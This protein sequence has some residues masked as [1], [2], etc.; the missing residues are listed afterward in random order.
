MYNLPP[1]L[2]MHLSVKVCIA[3]FLVLCP[4][5]PLSGTYC[6]AD[7]KGPVLESSPEVNYNSSTRGARRTLKESMLKGSI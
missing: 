3:A 5:L 6:S 1:P 7:L 4:R 2:A